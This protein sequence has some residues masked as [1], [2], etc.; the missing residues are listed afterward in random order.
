MPMNL[1][2]AGGAA[3]GAT[4]LALVDAHLGEGDEGLLICCGPADP[5]AQVVDGVLVIIFQYTHCCARL[6]QQTIC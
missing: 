4:H 5:A 3:F 2:T 1:E 6:A